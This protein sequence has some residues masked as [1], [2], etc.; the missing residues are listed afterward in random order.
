METSFQKRISQVM[1]K[2]FGRAATSFSQMINRPVSFAHSSTV[3]V[4]SVREFSYTPEDEGKVM[5]LTTGMIG[6]IRGKSFL[7][8]SEQEQKEICQA[9]SPSQ[10]LSVQYQQ[11]LLLEIDNIVSASVISQIANDFSVQIYG[12]VPM[13]KFM[14]SA[15]IRKYLCEYLESENS[16]SIILCNTTFLI[17]N[18][19][20]IHPQFI[21]KIGPEVFNLIEQSFARQ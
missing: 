9:V 10:P 13:M 3:I 20:H 7:I 5:V 4:Q 8:I 12:D 1:N 17:G 14:E 6:E 21:W 16:G 18:Q 15:D 11:A 19:K 2:G